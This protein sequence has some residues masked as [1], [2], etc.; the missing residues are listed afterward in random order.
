MEVIIA[1]VLIVVGLFTGPALAMALLW[2]LF[3]E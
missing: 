1:T 3:D 2:W